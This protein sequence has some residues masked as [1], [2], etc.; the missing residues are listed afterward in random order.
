MRYA[1]SDLVS[2]TLEIL[3]EFPKGVNTSFLIKEL[4]NRLKPEGQDIEILPTRKDTYFSQ[5][6]RNLKS[7]NTLTRKELANY[8]NGIFTITPKGRKYLYQGYKELSHALREQGFTEE[9]RDEEFQKDYKDL[10]VEEGLAII[11]TRDV[12]LRRR[13]KK[14][15][16][17]A[18]HFFDING[19][20]P[21]KV[22]GFDFQVKYGEL[23]KGYIEIHHTKP[24]HLHSEKGEK[25]ELEKAL[26]LLVPLC[27]NCHKMIH[28]DRKNLLSIERLA[29][30][31][32]AQI[33]I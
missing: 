19:K 16:E 21:C 20:I 6:V 24:I 30:V 13:S 28:R 26:D 10:V 4:I 8:T 15:V 33:N 5:K 3:M 23:G 18:K 31:V 11:M 12:K 17:I 25:R 2:P 1:E 27:S 32:K 9:E 7:H 29:E 22:C 14:L